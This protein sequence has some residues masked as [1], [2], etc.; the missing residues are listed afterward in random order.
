LAVLEH[1][2]LTY[3]LGRRVSSVAMVNVQATL[4][5]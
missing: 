2:G 5:R 1:N 4:G 3:A